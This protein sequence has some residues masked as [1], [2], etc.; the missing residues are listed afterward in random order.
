MDKVVGHANN[1]PYDLEDEDLHYQLVEVDVV[2]S[3]VEVEEG[4]C[5]ARKQVV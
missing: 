4:F 3:P 5:R 2:E 1:G